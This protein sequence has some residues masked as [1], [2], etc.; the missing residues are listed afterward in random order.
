MSRILRF[1]EKGLRPSATDHNDMVE[2]HRAAVPVSSPTVR[3]KMTSTGFT[4]HAAR[5]RRGGI[6]SRVP[7]VYDIKSVSGNKVTVYGGPVL[8]FNDDLTIQ[9]TEV[10][11]IG[12]LEAP[13]YIFATG[14][15][16][17][18]VTGI[19]E[20]DAVTD[21]PKHTGNAWVKLL[22]KVCLVNGRARVL[23]DLRHTI[24]LKSW[25]GP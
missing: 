5:Q 4:L 22:W 9:D 8:G 25:E 24:D 23:Q 16:R 13:S 20:T 2:A 12:N 3:V 17:P 15:V 6:I 1:T 19:I 14:V 10:T 21:R 11:V 18:N 7:A